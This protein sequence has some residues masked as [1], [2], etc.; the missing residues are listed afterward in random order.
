VKVFV[1]SAKIVLE[2]VLEVGGEIVF[3]F[4]DSEYIPFF[5]FEIDEQIRGFF[6]SSVFC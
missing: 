6:S 3:R 4:R 1:E 2:F 5:E